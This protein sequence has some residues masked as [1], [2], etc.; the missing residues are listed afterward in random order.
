MPANLPWPTPGRRRSHRRQLEAAILRSYAD[1]LAIPNRANDSANIRRNAEHIAGL[2]R[3]RGVRVDVA[4][5]ERCI[6]MMKRFIAEHP[7]LW[8]EDIG[9]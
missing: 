5:D 8:D 7:T 6:E 1:L 2:L 9:V 3:A 4:Q